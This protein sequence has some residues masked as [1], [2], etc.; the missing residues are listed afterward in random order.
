MHTLPENVYLPRRFLSPKPLIVCKVCRIFTDLV[1]YC[2]ISKAH[3]RRS[4]G[5]WGSCTI[6]L[7]DHHGELVDRIH[8]ENTGCE[9]VV[10][11]LASLSCLA[12]FQDKEDDGSDTDGDADGHLGCESLSEHQ[13]A[14]ED[15]G[16]R[17][18]DAE[19]SSLCG[20]YV[21]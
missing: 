21:A 20:A 11:S 15:G 16:E 17:F 5:V 7:F 18:E 2:T 6:Q 3:Q 13:S 12:W 8:A 4:G 1:D 9:W 19:D 14:D 10:R